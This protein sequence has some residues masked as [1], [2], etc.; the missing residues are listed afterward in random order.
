MNRNEYL[1][2]AMLKHPDSV[3]TYF[4]P[5]EKTRRG[6]LVLYKAVHTVYGQVDYIT[7]PQEPRRDEQ[8]RLFIDKPIVIKER[9]KPLFTTES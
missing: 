9:S 5:D 7:I 6:P 1:C 4:V 3:E 2:H 8:G